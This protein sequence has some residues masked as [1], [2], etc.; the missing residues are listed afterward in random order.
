MF[1][2]RTITSTLILLVFALVGVCGNNVA[3]TS[4][5]SELAYNNRNLIRLHIL[6]NSDSARD[7]RLKLMVRD[8]MIQ[9]TRRL[10]LKARTV[11]E[12]LAITKAN[13]PA[14]VAEA[15][16]VLR[17]AGACYQARIE[18]G[19]F[20]F[21]SRSYDFGTLPAGEYQAVRII[22][23]KGEGKNWWCVLFPPLC[24]LSPPETE[25]IAPHSGPVHVRV[26]FLERLLR[27]SGQRLDSF[28]RGWAHFLHL[29]VSRARAGPFRRP[30]AQKTA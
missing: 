17:H 19:R 5:R 25:N 13:R 10:F 12:A 18:L 8:A 15:N 24:F 2:R 7:Q 11:Q 16:N 28:W 29:T 20:P 23:G 21:P 9:K 6:A 26:L 1:L 22:L 3:L 30:S 27:S 14:L 4:E